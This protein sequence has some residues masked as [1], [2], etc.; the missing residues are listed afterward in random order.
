MKIERFAIVVL[1]FILAYPIDG[2][3]ASV[4]D[5][6]PEFVLNG[7][8]GTKYHSDRIIGKNPLMLVFWATWCPN[9]KDEIP[10]LKKIHT[11]FKTKGLEL[12]AVNVGINDSKAKTKRYIKKYKITYPVAFDDGSKITKRFEVQGTP[13]IIIIDKRGVVKY[14][15]AAVPDDLEK[16]YESLIK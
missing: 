13:T 7:I 9:C 1:L 6:S 14:R 15:S 10:A 3:A 8:D 12:I 4:E 11:D 16:H 5:I 2:F